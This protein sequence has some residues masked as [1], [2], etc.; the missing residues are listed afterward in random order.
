MT[1]HDPRVTLTEAETERLVST[2]AAA[3]NHQSIDAEAGRSDLGLA[4]E[5]V[6]VQSAATAP[7]GLTRAVEQIVAEH[8]AARLA[9]IRAIL[10][11][12]D[13]W[14]GSPGPDGRLHP[15]SSSPRDRERLRNALDAPQ[16]APRGG[17]S[18][19]E[20]AACGRLYLDEDG[21]K[22]YCSWP[23]GHQGSCW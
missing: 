5:I 19:G 4:E 2:I 11:A 9:P 12:W 18:E 7:G 16:D 14:D 23:A 13:A 21:D 3:I 8:V 6:Y 15:D 1:A 20:S 17:Q 22:D 10:A